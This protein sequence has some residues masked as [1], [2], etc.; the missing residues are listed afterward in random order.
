MVNIHISIGTGFQIG[1][2]LLIACLAAYY[3]YRRFKIPNAL[4]YSAMIS[5][6]VWHL[7]SPYGLGV[8]TSIGGITFGF[9]SL[10]P[11]FIVGGMGAGDVKLM[12]AIGAILGFKPTA[13]IFLASALVTGV[14][15][16]YLMIARQC[17]AM[18]FDRLKLIYRKF[19]IFGHH[20]A[21]DD[22]HRTEFDNPA[23]PATQTTM[24]PFGVMVAFGMLLIYGLAI[25]AKIL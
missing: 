15:A 8:Y 14:Y 16:V 13:I 21:V 19:M 10:L 20:L 25:S 3:D 5:G 7:A 11:F 12:M 4:T 22:H 23:R 18:T 9:L 2:S 17:A 6:M 24:I 1:F